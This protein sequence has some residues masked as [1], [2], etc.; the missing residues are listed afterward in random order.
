MSFIGIF[1]IFVLVATFIAIG[2]ILYMTS[3]ILGKSAAEVE[4]DHHIKLT[5]DDRNYKTFE[6]IYLPVF[7]ANMMSLFEGNQMI[8]N[9]YSEADQPQNFFM[10]A[11]V[12]IVCLTLFIACAVGYIGYL[13]FGETTK[14]VILYNLPNDDPI[15][16]TAKC[17]YILTICGSFVLIIQPIFSIVERSGWYNNWFCP[18]EKPE[19][20]LDNDDEKKSKKSKAEKE[21]GQ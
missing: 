2:L 10:Q 5:E 8:L 3:T 17:L 11:A 4:A 21:G 15:S 20:G 19:D 9:L 14:S 13:A 16:I 7:C 18:N 1:S 12:I 6:L